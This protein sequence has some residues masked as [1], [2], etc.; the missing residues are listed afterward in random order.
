MTGDF[1]VF[2]DPLVASM[3][4]VLTQSVLMPIA[5]LL[6]SAGAGGGGLEGEKQQRVAAVVEEVV[7]SLENSEVR[8]SVQREIAKLKELLGTIIKQ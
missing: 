7:R 1:G 2:G 8:G 3:T 6:P 5:S 4:A